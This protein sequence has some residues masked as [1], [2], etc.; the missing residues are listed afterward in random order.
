MV[1][2]TSCSSRSFTFTA[3]TECSFA[4]FPIRVH[5]CIAK[6]EPLYTIAEALSI[7]CYNSVH[8]SDDAEVRIKETCRT[9]G[10][11]ATAHRRSRRGAARAAWPRANLDQQ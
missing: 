9:A 3:F 5:H 11:N 4:L 7:W 2:A 6:L 10:R 1:D 8:E